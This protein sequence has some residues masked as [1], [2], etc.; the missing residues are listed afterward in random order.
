MLA[1]AA[2]GKIAA[3]QTFLGGS[4]ILTLPLAWFMVAKGF[5]FVAIGWAM[6]LTMM[7]C[8]CGRVW[9]ARKLV[10]MSARYW[11]LKIMAP[12]GIVVSVVGAAGYVPHLV[13]GTGL[14]RVFATTIVCELLL[15]PL[16]W[17]VLLDASERLYLTNR[18][19]SFL[20]K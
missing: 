7:M 9:F 20:Q 19:G 5:G 15:L 13:L 8:S 4:L 17:F 6:V 12:I 2:K 1:V 10:G 11:L 18:I 14:P 16:T 3:Y